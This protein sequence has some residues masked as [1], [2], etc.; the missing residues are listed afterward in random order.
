MPPRVNQPSTTPVILT[1]N[2]AKELIV[3]KSNHA[4]AYGTAV[5]DY[6]A[7]YKYW[8]SSKKCAY[9]AIAVPLTPTQF[10]NTA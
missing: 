5:Y 4:M 1:S 6:N 8:L 10:K 2:Q 9:C 3:L 7:Y